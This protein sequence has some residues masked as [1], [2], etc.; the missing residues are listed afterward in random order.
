MD[1]T[2]LNPL[3][4][5]M[6]IKCT[7]VKPVSP[8]QS[9]KEWWERNCSFT[10]V[11][12]AISS[13]NVP[14]CKKARLISYQWRADETNHH[15][16]YSPFSPA[17]PGLPLVVTVFS[18]SPRPHWLSCWSKFHRLRLRPTSLPPDRKHL[19]HLTRHPFTVQ[20]SSV[21]CISNFS[22]TV[23]CHNAVTQPNCLT[24][25]PSPVPTEPIDLT[26]F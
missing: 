15:F 11:Y 13:P 6:K 18:T 19:T 1:S 24:A 20:Y 26:L 17:T 10:V 16:P 22:P 14:N 5:T 2:S 12:L 21:S 4:I 7:W 23:F 25:P 3:P 8:S 9:G